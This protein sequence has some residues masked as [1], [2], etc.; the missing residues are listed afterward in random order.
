MFRAVANVVA[1]PAFP[2]MSP[3][4]VDENVLVPAMVWVVVRST[5]FCVADPVPPFAMPNL[6]VTPVLK[7]SPVA[8]VNTPYAGVP[9]DGEVYVGEVKVLL[10]NVSV[11]SKVAKVPDAD[12]SVIVVVP[13]TAGAIGTRDATNAVISRRARFMPSSLWPPPVN[14]P[15]LPSRCRCK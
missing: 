6:P 10:V 15:L 12:G 1:V 4:M 5:K 7:G 14:L 8:L 3:V 9:K 11:P 2:L 13:A